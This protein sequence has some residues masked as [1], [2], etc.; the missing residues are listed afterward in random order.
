MSSKEISDYV[1]RC[2]NEG[3]A[4]WMYK[5][6]PRPHAPHALLASLQHADG[7]VDVGKHIKGH[8]VQ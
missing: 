7:Y 6:P 1:E 8:P 4:M 3:G 5:G 2:L